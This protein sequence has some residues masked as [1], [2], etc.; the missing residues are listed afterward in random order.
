MADNSRKKF[1][2]KAFTSLYVTYS[3]LIMIFTGIILYIAPAGRIAKWSHISILGLEKD[4]WQAIHIIFTFLFIVAG[5][6]HLYYNWKPFVS[7]LKTKVQERSGIRKELVLSTFVTLVILLTTLFN[8]PPFSYVI[9]LGEY[10]TDLWATEQTEPPVPH[11]EAMSIKELS[12]AIN[13]PVE[14]L[15]KNL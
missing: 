12:K 11:A 4:S 15:L 3:F 1:S 8:L 5:G 13:I 2:W 6:F 10:F 14:D 7:Y 9:D